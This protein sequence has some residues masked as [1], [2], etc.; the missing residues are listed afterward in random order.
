MK[1]KLIRKYKKT[2]YTIGELYIN[3]QLFCST[4]EDKD[5][6][7]TSAMTE[8][9]IFDVK[10]KGK[11]A[12]PLGIYSVTWTYSPHFKK[13]MLAVNGVKGFAGI[14]IHAGNT[15]EHTD[16]CILVGRNTKVGQ[17]TCSRSTLAELTLVIRAAMHGGQK[18]ELEII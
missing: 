8:N 3:G 15:A 9:E 6:G 17:L 13:Y 1:L 10:V 16:G 18:I 7:L 11:T 2:T 14:R 12:I 4:L 5:R